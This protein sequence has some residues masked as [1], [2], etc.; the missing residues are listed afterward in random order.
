MNTRAGRPRF[1]V[2]TAVYDPVPE[3]LAACI[4]SVERQHADAVAG[5]EHVLVDDGSTDPAVAAILAGAE[6]RGAIVRRR[7]ANGG[8]VAASS[9]ALDA[10]TGEWL[11]LLDHDD[12]LA[13]G[14]LQR[15]ERAL[16]VDPS[17]DVLYTDHDLIRADGRFV[18][19]VYKPD[20]SPERLR[21]T[22]YITHLVVARRAAVESVGG[23]RP[24]TDGAQD[25]DLLLRLAER[26]QR[27][28]HLPEVLAHWRQSPASVA[29]TPANKP[30]AFDAGVRVV[31]EHVD[32]CG[33]AAEVSPGRYPGT[34][35]IDRRAD[36]EEL[37]SVVLPT[38]GSSGRVWGVRRT[39]VVDAV[40]SIAERSTHRA[41]EFVIVADDDTPEAV[42]QALRAVG[43]RHRLPVEVTTCVGPFN[44]SAK[45]NAGV[46]ASSGG[47]VLLLNDDTELIQPE[48]IGVMA[49]HLQHP[50]AGETAHG[51]VGAVGAK[52]LYADGTLQ[53]GGHVYHGE[54]MHAF[55]GWPGDHPGPQRMLAIERE[56]SGVTAAALMTTRAVF[57]AVGGFPEDLPLH[58]NDVEFC[59]AVRATGRRILWT[60]HACWYHFEGRSRDRGASMAEWDRVASN[61]WPDGVPFDPYANPNL[62]PKRPD[63]LELPG[64][65]G[66]P[67]Y[68]VDDEGVQRFA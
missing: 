66:A 61:W 38:R 59:L 41:V 23:F 40:R 50:G 15:V 28:G 26:G 36:P 51:G 68:F 67:P 47:L 44:F 14:A 32:R 33:I 35:R 62:A 24:G 4:A 46:R 21:Q 48:S 10:A 34:Y 16:G 27:F 13:D 5:V 63:W 64:R 6:R 53:H 42:L 12:L 54:F 58:F 7:D 25:H 43:A 56:C 9:D 57:D 22:N 45:V 31:A 3:H 52:L 30:S 11:V 19:P 55:L 2:L 29:T 60:P 39:F 49:A 20:F 17:V 18:E 1:S 65:S 8:I 37:V